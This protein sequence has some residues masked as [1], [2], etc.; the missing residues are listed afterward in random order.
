M[1]TNNHQKTKFTAVVAFLLGLNLGLWLNRDARIVS[2]SLKCKHLT[3][4]K[5]RPKTLKQEI[6]CNKEFLLVAVYINTHKNIVFNDFGEY[7]RTKFIF[8]TTSKTIALNERT[9]V[10]LENLDAT[11]TDVIY[12]RMLR[13]VS[14]QYGNKFDWFILTESSF[15]VNID[16]LIFLRNLNNSEK[17][18]FVPEMKKAGISNEYEYNIE[19]MNLKGKLTSDI[20][21]RESNQ[22]SIKDSVNDTGNYSILTAGL[23]DIIQPGII[24]S[25]PL[26]Q[27]LANLTDMC[28]NIKN[29]RQCL[30]NRIKISWFNYFKVNV[31]C[32]K[33]NVNC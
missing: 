11:S 24:F 15:F 32:D 12:L 21:N 4:I 2:H 19:R 31:V 13:H 30:K 33:K 17:F 8:F 26:V 25:R 29:F 1:N 20:R 5:E 16:K 6:E 18:L 9:V 23:I 28:E 27:E 22:T 3:V 7:T 10:R 14:Q